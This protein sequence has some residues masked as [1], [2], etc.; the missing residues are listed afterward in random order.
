M[1]CVSL[2]A[3][4]QTMRQKL[5]ACESSLSHAPKEYPDDAIEDYQAFLEY[6]YKD[7]FT[8]L[9]YREY[10]YQTKDGKPFGKTVKNSHLGLLRPDVKTEIMP[11]GFD[12]LPPHLARFYKDKALMRVFKTEYQIDCAPFRSA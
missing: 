6:L 4:W 10:V 12:S 11:E 1:T 7:N 3:D 8:L 9:G 2:T 5:R